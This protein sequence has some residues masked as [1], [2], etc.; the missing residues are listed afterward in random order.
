MNG[1]GVGFGG[2]GFGGVGVGGVGFGGVGF[3][4]VGFG[5]GFLGGLGLGAGLVTTASATASA[6]GGFGTCVPVW[7]AT[8]FGIGP[9]WVACS[10]ATMVTVSPGLMVPRLH[11][12]G[13]CVK[14]QLP[15]L[16][17]SDRILE[18]VKGACS[19]TCTPC[20]GA[21]PVFVALIV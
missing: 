8:L 21:S 7:T 17:D 19:A 15:W 3:G 9:G 14:S 4:G 16:G 20:A 10:A 6:V 13:A 1:G 5:A 12:A 11:E 18:L 2:V